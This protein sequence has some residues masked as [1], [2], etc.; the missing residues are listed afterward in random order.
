MCIGMRVCIPYFVDDVGKGAVAVVAIEARFVLVIGGPEIE[1][2]IAIKIA[3]RVAPTF[4][5][6]RNAGVLG[7]LLKLYI[8]PCWRWG[9]GAPYP[10]SAYGEDQKNS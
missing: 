8:T 5:D 1:I 2:S 9:E 10:D 7:H 4:T 3:P 6:T